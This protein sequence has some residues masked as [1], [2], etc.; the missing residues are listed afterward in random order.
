MIE[1]GDYG[2]YSASGCQALQNKDT[3]LLVTATCPGNDPSCPCQDGDACH[4]K[5]VGGT[6][7]WPVPKR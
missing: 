1:P 4:Y 6:P 2:D 5:A 7:A 3:P